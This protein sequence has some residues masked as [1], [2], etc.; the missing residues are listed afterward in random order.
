MVSSQDASETVEKAF[1]ELEEQGRTELAQEGFSAEQTAIEPF[2]DLRY[3]GQSYELT[4]PF[5]EDIERAITH[6]HAAHEKRFGYNDPGERVQVVNVRLKA[7]GVVTRPTLERQEEQHGATATAQETRPVVFAGANGV[8]A[9][10]TAIYE[11]EKLVAGT[12]IQGPAIITQYDTTTVIPPEWQ[13][14]VDILGNLIAERKEE[15]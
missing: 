6:F 13:A 7:R 2:L 9:H 8:T 5:E 11:R 1:S 3:V 12:N 15:Q 10:D 14:R 4:V